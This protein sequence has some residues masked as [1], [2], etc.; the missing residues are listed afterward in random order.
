GQLSVG[1]AWQENLAF[2]RRYVMKDGTVAWNPGKRNPN[3]DRPAGAIDPQIDILRIDRHGAKAPAAILTRFP[4]HPDTVGGTE[5]S[6]DFPHYLEQTLRERLSPDFMSIFAQGTS[7]N[8]NHVNVNTDDPQKG[9]AEA[10][11]IRA[12]LGNHV[13]AALPNLKPLDA[14]T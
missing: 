14:P 7:G 1:H 5:Y 4:L 13:L 6:A 12:A 2:N 10:N 11:R 8:I 3:I 9:H